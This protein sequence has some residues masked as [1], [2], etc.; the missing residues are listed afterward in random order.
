MSIGHANH[1]AV[2]IDAEEELHT[3]CNPVCCLKAVNELKAK[4]QGTDVK[5]YL[6]DFHDMTPISSADAS[7][8]HGDFPTTMGYGLLAFKD[9]SI[10]GNFA[11]EIG[12]EVL[13]WGE[14]RIRHESPDREIEIDLV[15]VE[16][17]P[18]FEVSRGQIV[19]VSFRNRSDS[20]IKCNLSGYDFGLTVSAASIQTGAFIADKPGQG[21][22]FQNNDGVILGTLFVRGD[23]TSEEA[24]YR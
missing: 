10:A 13:S 21:F 18:V 17:P 19:S 8:V 4:G 3:F 22:V 11:A 2:F 12:G 6:F 9:P 16:D 20:D 15:A 7:V 14:L 23:H 5:V 1:G 24:I